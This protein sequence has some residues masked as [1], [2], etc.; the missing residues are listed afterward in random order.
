MSSEKVISY[1]CPKS[2]AVVEY[3]VDNG[4]E[5]RQ[6]YQPVVCRACGELHFVHRDTGKLLGHDKD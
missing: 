1:R 5:T 4:G 2:D 3:R 6:A